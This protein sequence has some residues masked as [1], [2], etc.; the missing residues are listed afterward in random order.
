MESEE[1]IKIKFLRLNFYYTV[2]IQNKKA[3]TP[4]I[5]NVS[6]LIFLYKVLIEKESITNL[7]GIDYLFIIL[8]KLDLCVL[9]LIRIRMKLTWNI[10]VKLLNQFNNEKNYSH[11]YN[12][13]SEKKS[14][15]A[16]DVIIII[17]CL[18]SVIYYLSKINFCSWHFKLIIK[19][20]QIFKKFLIM[21]F[22]D[23]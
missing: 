1:R 12:F 22:Q 18:C 7:L 16:I 11:L 9:V 21:T 8:F 23:L 17:I 13:I 2:L 4:S 6:I 20:N 15:F 14:Y 5:K 19:V 10:T 3:V